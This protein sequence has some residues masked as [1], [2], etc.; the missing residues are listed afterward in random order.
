MIRRILVP[1]DG[2]AFGEHALVRALALA[3]QQG[4]TLDLAHVHEVASLAYLEGVPLIDAG[5]EL[6]G[7]QSDRA[8]LD[9]MLARITATGVSATATLLDGPTVSA[10][11][12]TTMPISERVPCH[13][14]PAR[15]PAMR[16]AE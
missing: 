9:R 4:A 5:V 7:I 6:E 3:K 16:P 13:I 10:L 1:L 15:A 11:E 12:M 8:Y 2:S 14:R